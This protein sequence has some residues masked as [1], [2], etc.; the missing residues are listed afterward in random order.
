MEEVLKPKP[1][2]SEPLSRTTLRVYAS[3]RIR[4]VLV[5]GIKPQPLKNNGIHGSFQKVKQ[6]PQLFAKRRLIRFDVMSEEQTQ[7]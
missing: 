1:F 2:F 6:Q 4:F 3:S 7:I 5:L